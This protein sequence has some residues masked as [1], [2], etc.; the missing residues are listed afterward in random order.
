M[1]IAGTAL[2]VLQQNG[3]IGGILGNCGNARCAELE[4]RIAQLTAEKY[5]DTAVSAERERR[6]A[7]E[8]RTIGYT[9]EIEKRLSALETASPLKE[10]IINQKIDNVANMAASGFNNLQAAINGVR[11]QAKEW[12]DLEA[13]RRDCA[14]NKIVC[15]ANG[16]FAPKG[17]VNPTYGTTPTA[18]TFFNPLGCNCCDNK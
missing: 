8:E 14:D 2:G 4:S 12:V 10:Q 18:E 15:Y 16:H 17:K 9:I 7:L 1:G 6:L 11:A 3:G 5:A 13:E